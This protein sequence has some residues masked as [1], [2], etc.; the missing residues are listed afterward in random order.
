[1]RVEIGTRPG[2]VVP[3]G[4]ALALALGAGALWA[5]AVALL[6]PYPAHLRRGILDVQDG[7]P[8]SVTYGLAQLRVLGALC[9]LALAHVL[10]TRAHSAAFLLMRLDG[11]R[12]RTVVP[13]AVPVARALTWLAVVALVIGGFGAD[14]LVSTTDCF[15]TCAPFPR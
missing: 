7:V 11:L 12:V 1:M 4:R 14:S 3:E 15:R 13:R 5:L 2:L 6:V 8:G 9:L 10:S